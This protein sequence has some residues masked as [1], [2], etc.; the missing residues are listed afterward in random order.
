MK[1]THTRT[2]TRPNGLA[3]V[4]CCLVAAHVRSNLTKNATRLSI[5]LAQQLVNR[6]L[7]CAKEQQSKSGWP[8]TVQRIFGASVSLL[9]WTFA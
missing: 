7:L 8:R 6:K 4:V 5:L 1:V 2:N 3:M 9:D